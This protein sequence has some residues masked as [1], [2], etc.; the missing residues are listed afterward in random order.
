[1]GCSG[2]AGTA[3]GP[4]AQAGAPSVDAP[5]ANVHLAADEAG[6]ELLVPGYGPEHVEVTVKVT[7]DDA[8]ALTLTAT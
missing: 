2:D 6:L 1:M 4:L 5:R 7:G 3:Q 8:A